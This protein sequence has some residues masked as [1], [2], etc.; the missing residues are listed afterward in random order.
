MISIGKKAPSFSLP[1]RDGQRHSLSKFKEDFLVVYFYPKDNTSGCTIEAREFQKQLKKFS[2]L[3]A[4][5]VG[6]SGGDEKSK[7]KFCE[8]HGLK[9]PLLSD[10]DFK[11]A[12]KYHS[13]GQM[14]FMGRKFKSVLRNTFVLDKKRRIVQVFEKVSAPGHAKEVLNFL[15]TCQ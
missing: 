1:D 6:I 12:R 10:P 8:N 9:F 4:G 7:T 11:V 2:A 5:V 13:Y 14:T 3:G 15:K